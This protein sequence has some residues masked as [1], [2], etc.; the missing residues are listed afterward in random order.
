MRGYPG[1]Q[2]NGDHGWMTTLEGR[3]QFQPTLQGILF[4]D[5]GT[6]RLSEN[7]LLAP[8]D[9][10]QKLNMYSLRGWGVGVNYSLHSQA[11]VK[12]TWSRRIGSNPVA[13][14]QTGADVD[15]TRLM[16]RFWAN[17]SSFF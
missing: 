1:N 11:T 9:N 6:I 4:Y 8:P 16:N 10:A 17:V 2:G 13:N 5:H 15:G 7:P 12:L 3:Q 14:P